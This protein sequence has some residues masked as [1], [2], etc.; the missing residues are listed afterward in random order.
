MADQ[1]GRSYSAMFE[2]SD[3]FERHHLSL[4]AFEPDSM[5]LLPRPYP[6][7]LPLWFKSAD[8]SQ[9]RPAE[10]EELQFQLVPGS[11]SVEGKLGFAIESAWIEQSNN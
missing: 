10:I 7:F 6:T 1:N 5:M 2:V 3:S 11:E 9:L 8:N 4:N